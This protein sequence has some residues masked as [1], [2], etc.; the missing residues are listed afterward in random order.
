MGSGLSRPDPP[1]SQA[2]PVDA[3]VGQK[4]A[5]HSDGPAA[6]KLEG[7]PCATRS[8]HEAIKLLAAPTAKPTAKPAMKKGL[9]SWKAAL[10]LHHEN[11]SR[12]R[13]EMAARASKIHAVLSLMAPHGCVTGGGPVWP[14]PGG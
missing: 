1:A 13:L 2:A 5:I 12:L 3:P 8:L 9:S 11:E 4:V 14:A 6:V 7:G 10:A